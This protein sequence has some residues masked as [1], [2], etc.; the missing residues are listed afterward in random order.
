MLGATCDVIEPTSSGSHFFLWR[1]TGCEGFIPTHVFDVTV[2]LASETTAIRQAS[3]GVM[4]GFELEFSLQCPTLGDVLN[5]YEETLW[6]SG[7]G[8]LSDEH[9]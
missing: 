9:W 1:G 4:V 7:F 2:K 5:L 6:A 8:W 3:H